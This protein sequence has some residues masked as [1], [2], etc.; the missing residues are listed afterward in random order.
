MDKITENKKTL[1]IVV[2]C[3]NEE[4]NVAPLVAEIHRVTGE[5]LPNYNT[6][7]LFI[8]NCSTDRTREIL[9]GICAE[10]KSVKAI[11]NAKNFGHIRSPFHA[12]TQ[13][14]GDLVMLMCADFQDPPELIPEFV[15]KWE[16]GYRVIVGTKKKSKTNPIIH[17]IRKLYYHIIHRISEVEQIENFTGFGLYDQ[18]FIQVLAKLE[19]PYP[20]MRGIVAELGF[21]MATIEYTQPARRA[22]KSHNNFG[23]LYDMAMNGITSYSKFFVRIAAFIG[24]FLGF[25]GIAGLIVYLVFLFIAIGKDTLHPNIVYPIIASSAI[26]T[27]IIL[28]FVGMV[29]EYVLQI[30]TRVLKRPYVIEEERLNFPESGD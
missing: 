11:F 12:L 8:D 23:T 2:A 20:Y 4:E 24:A 3:Y 9:R 28:F 7:I 1:T 21:K 14:K 19:D 16:E 10:D 26:F 18:A 5:S 6:E 30:N 17:A 27:G 25:L 15:K 13:A 29:G 22:G